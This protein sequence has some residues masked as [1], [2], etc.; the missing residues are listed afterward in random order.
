MLAHTRRLFPLAAGLVAIT[1]LSCAL[2][3]DKVPLL[4]PTG[5]VISLFASS[6]TIPLNSEIEIVA[7]VIENG[8]APTT[9]TTP[10][11]PANPGATPAPTTTTSTTTAGAGTPVQNGTLVSF[12][13]TIGRIEPSEARTNNG[14]V[15]VKFI[16]SGQSGTATITAFSGGASGKLE[17]LKVGSA[18][19]ERVLI[20]ASPQT[21]GPS[22]GSATITARVEDVSGSGLSGVPVTFTTD[23]G[24][25][26]SPSVNTD[27]LGVAQTTLTT[28]RAAKVTANVAGKTADV[29]VGL[30]PRTG[31]SISPPSTQVSAGQPAAFAIKITSGSTGNVP[32]IRDVTVDFGDGR[33]QSLGAISGDATIQHT[34][35]EAGTYTVRATAIDVSGFTEQ[36]AT[37]ITV[38][39]GQPPGVTITA[40]NSSPTV[41]Q[42]ITLTAV[43]QGQ[44][45]TIQRYEW[46]FGDGTT[47]TTTGPQITKSYLTIGTKVIRVTVVQAVGPSGQ[48]QTTVDVKP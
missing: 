19:A 28:S 5:S 24:S 10:T 31:I 4:A 7:N 17:N 16:S 22:G 36:V 33:S 6:S 30:N 1:I 3:C 2:A 48:G 38:L 39:P 21:L 9:P 46:D 25:L 15:R 47:A 12:T 35:N 8:T 26:S 32:N 37:S 14:Q 13:T 18:G 40:S 41:G 42:I 23:A 34:Y 11:T 29:T 45:S 27:S 43:A 20:T 44:T